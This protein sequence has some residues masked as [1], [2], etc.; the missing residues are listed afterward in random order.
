MSEI[1][2]APP[3]I[4][5]FCAESTVPP[6]LLKDTNIMGVLQKGVTQWSRISAWSW[7]DYVA[8]NDNKNPPVDLGKAKQEENL[9][10]FLI[11]GLTQQAQNADGWISYGNNDARIQ[12]NWWSQIIVYLL[13]GDN[14]A[15]V[16]IAKNKLGEEVPNFEDMQVTLS[17][18]L[19]KTTGEP[20]VTSVP[21]NKSFVDLF[22]VQ[23]TRD[24]FTGRLVRASETEC[25]NP[26]TPYVNI[27]AYP[28]RPELGPLT[29]TSDQLESWASG[30]HKDR[31]L[32]PSAYI[33][34]ATT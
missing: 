19:Y 13:L 5:G 28:P 4:P 30:A 6:E 21:E 29:V 17:D 25:G 8:F 20:L 1:P 7:C 10:D 15:A 22:Y 3:P 9:K 23:I 34:I 31:Y 27:I 16:D 18:V 11:R 14:E 32:P 24:A 33:P 2:T 26:Y 12:A